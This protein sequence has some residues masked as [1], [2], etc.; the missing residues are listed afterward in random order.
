MGDLEL[1][2]EK[3]S[4]LGLRALELDKMI[5]IFDRQLIDNRISFERSYKGLAE[6]MILRKLES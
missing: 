6:V 4:C 2:E 5:K 1:A 3:M